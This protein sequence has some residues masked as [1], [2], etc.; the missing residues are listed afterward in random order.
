MDKI[1][2]KLLALL[3][4]DASLSNQQLAERV[5]LSPSQC[6]RRLQRLQQDGYVEKQVA[7]LNA[8]RIGLLVEAYVMVTLTSYARSAAA[9]FH[10][11]MREHPAVIECCS[12]TGDS[13]YI[14]RVVAANLQQFSK[15][16]HEDL[17]GHGEVANIRSSIVLDKIK[18]TTELPL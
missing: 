6:S 15:V 1:D 3:Q 7:L 16:V 5:H 8:E 17:L 18:R 13:D 12:L 4:S 11:R 9:A 14:L 2:R 10:E